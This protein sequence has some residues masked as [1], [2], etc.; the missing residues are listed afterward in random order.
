MRS[1]HSILLATAILSMAAALPRDQGAAVPSGDILAGT[2]G[3]GGCHAGVAPPANAGPLAAQDP[4]ALFAYL[5]D[6]PRP[7]EGEA[8]MPSFRLDEGEAAALALALASG[9]P[10]SEGGDVRRFRAARD[11]Q[12]AA[13][14]EA[15]ARIRDALQCDVC[16]GG[17]PA[18]AAPP[19]T[20]AARRLKR[21]WLQAYL[22]Q[23]HDVR[24]FGWQPGAGTRMPDFRLSATE[25]DTLV[26]WL[27]RLSGAQHAGEA[28]PAPS[29]HTAATTE[30]LLR[31]RWGCMGCHAWNGAGGRIGP[32]L[33]RTGARLQPAHVRA[34]LADPGRAL[35][36][37]I[38]PRPQLPGRDLDRIAALLTNHAPP[39]SLPTPLSRLAN[40][41]APVPAGEDAV[42]LYGRLCSACHGP[43]GGGDGWNAPYLRGRP[44]PHANADTLRVRTDDRL[45]D[46]IHAGG[47][48]LGGSGDMPAFGGS[49]EDERIR[50]LVS[51]LRTLCACE[52]P[53]W[54]R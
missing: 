27:D 44:T 11:A 45:Y 40:R 35:A 23:P 16:H 22:A 50:A 38:M 28:P 48:I 25:I 29:G 1:H 21:D 47:R 10:G 5:L 18:A 34:I 54:S 31:E 43:A 7:A 51:H 9:D 42:A 12:P 39:D 20:D 30:T 2:L 14:A 26:A 6:P 3:C 17:A 32:D 41:T 37:G 53:A 15:G 33:A 13:T 8:R 49:L 46:G 19:L 52:G 36:S 4:A 24:P